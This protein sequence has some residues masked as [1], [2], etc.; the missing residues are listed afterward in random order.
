MRHH[1]RH[2][3]LLA[4]CVPLSACCALGCAATPRSTRLQP[5]DFNATVQHMVERLA[6]SDFLAPRDADSEPVY[7]TIN[8]VENLTS[9]IITQAEQWMLM[10]RVQGALSK[11][12]LAR[13]RVYFQITPEQHARLRAEGFAGDLDRLPRTTHVM[14]AVFMSA[15]RSERD[16][17]HGYTLGEQDYYYLEYTIT[18]LAT[19]HTV[20]T[21]TFE[22]KRQAVGLAI[23]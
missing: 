17:K 23:D 10:A 7:I 11:P 4:L 5:E 1:P 18:D 12:A 15:R 13:K 20:W 6:A 19:R 9:D 22:F 8:K 3:F 21:E 14:K 16:P 2:T